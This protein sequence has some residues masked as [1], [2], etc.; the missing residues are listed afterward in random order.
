MTIV[1]VHTK[2]NPT[3]YTLKGCR[4]GNGKVMTDNHTEGIITQKLIH[5]PLYNILE[6]TTFS[7]RN[8][9]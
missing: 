6:S 2:S 4:F 1:E 5:H 8:S 7:E 3:F 9:T